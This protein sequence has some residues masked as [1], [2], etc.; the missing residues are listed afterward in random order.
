MPI[1]NVLKLYS[2]TIQSSFLH[3]GFWD[4][5]SSVEIE[6][7]TLQDIKNAQL[8]YIEHLASFI[9][10]DVD[11]IIDVGCG[12]GG[13]TEFLIEKGYTLETLSPDDFQKSIILKKF[14]HQIPFHHCTFENFNPQKQYDLILQSESACYIKI[15]EGF[16]KAREVLCKKG[17]LLVSDYFIHFQD[18]SNNLHLKSSHNLEQYLLIAKKYGFT[19][20]KEY[21][22]TENTMITLDYAKYFLKRFIDPAINY[23][24][25]SSEKSYPKISF[26]IGKI[27]SPKWE[28]KRKQLDLIESSLFRKYR[29]YMVYLFKKV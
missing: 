8:R 18:S 27:I 17:Y 2:E 14:N 16:E 20:I 29:K 12:I 21:D 24:I 23:G 9:P 13:N 1:D 25:Y 5:P 10:K 28:K 26:L 3:Y 6:S 11:S 19:L 15:D 7:L 22:Q 4:N